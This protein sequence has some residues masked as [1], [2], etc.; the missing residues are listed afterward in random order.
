M[1]KSSKAESACF[2]GID[3]AK[4]NLDVALGESAAPERYANDAKGRR[5]LCTKLAGLSPTKIVL[6]A[7]GGYEEPLLR[8]LHKAG[9]PAVRVNPR[10][11]RDFARAAGVLA[12]TDAIDARVL[13]R[14]AR[15]MDP[16]LRHGRSEEDA[17]LQRLIA[18]RRQLVELRVQELNRMGTESSRAVLRCLKRMVR[19]VEESLEQ[20][21]QEIADL[22]A[23]QK[24]LERKVEV[25]SSVPGVGLVTA[26]T[27]LAEMPELGTL[28]RQAIASL[29]GLAPFADDSGNRQGRR[30]IRGGRADVRATLYMATLVAVRHNP[31]IREDY[32]RLL[33][34]GK[35]PKVALVA[36]T[37]K[38]LTIL[39]AM[40]RDDK[41]WS[42][43]KV[44]NPA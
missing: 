36:C 16:P 11:V 26:A 17:E 8:S 19:T 12:K 28:P 34:A 44:E 3:V 37:R 42:H 38:L 7:T 10:P 23:H 4:A 18:R 25:L 27:L 6:E 41:P 39:N 13:S 24:T 15:V 40:V 35:L 33:G 1:S 30:S 14:Y 21:E 5:R 20:L 29:A 43:G 2:V 32:Q 31:V 22:I 9:L